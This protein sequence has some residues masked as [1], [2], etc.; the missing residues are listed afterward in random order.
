MN[1]WNF[2]LS[3]Y[4]QQSTFGSKNL[5]AIYHLV[6]HELL[7]FWY[8][9]VT[10]NPASTVQTR[11]SSSSNVQY[12]NVGSE[13]RKTFVGFD[14]RILNFR[15][16]VFHSLSPSLI[17][18]SHTLHSQ[19]E[20]TIS[21]AFGKYLAFQSIYLLHK[22]ML[23]AS[24]QLFTNAR[25]PFWIWFGMKL[26]FFLIF[27]CMPC[28]LCPAQE[29][30]EKTNEI[31]I[32]QYIDWYLRHWCAGVDVMGIQINAIIDR[33]L[34]CN[35]FKLN[36]NSSASSPHCTRDNIQEIMCGINN[37]CC[38]VCIILSIDFRIQNFVT[39]GRRIAIV[40]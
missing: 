11:E 7:Q 21:F 28:V 25:K 17:S 30:N 38:R 40:W 1:D 32:Y 6:K 20:Q 8:S 5:F 34:H 22:T 19:F 15:L 4:H 24:T 16:H 14:S 3:H 23:Q 10:V 31:Y 18:H 35:E 12:V 36:E 27:K 33:K 39:L 29:S 26:M 37:G 13:I 2:D 9:K